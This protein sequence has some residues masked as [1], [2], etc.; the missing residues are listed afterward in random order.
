MKIKSL[1]LKNF[2]RFTDLTLQDIPENAKL[3]LLIGANGSGKSSVFDG[4]EVIASQSRQ[5]GSVY[6]YKLEK[7][8]ESQLK[9]SVETY[10]YGKEE[11]SINS[12]WQTTS[13]L[14]FGNFYGRTS[15]RQISR[16][17]RNKLGD[18]YFN[19]TLDGD[20]PRTFIDRDERFEN[21]LENLFGK[22]LKEFFRTSTDKSEI[23]ENV[24]KSLDL[25]AETLNAIK[26][27]GEIDNPI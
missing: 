21:D 15:F 18:V 12:G 19:I 5:E 4:F 10:E 25:F 23:K 1:Q 14:H 11:G 6:D 17:K 3:V 7:N 26:K 2:K 22:L 16:L 24:I 9:I 8:L 27:Q 13:Q 20:R